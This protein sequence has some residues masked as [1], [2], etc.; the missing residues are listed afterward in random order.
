MEVL[1]VVQVPRELRNFH[2]ED[3][4]VRESHRQLLIEL[5]EHLSGEESENLSPPVI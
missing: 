1:E 2:P 3:Q 4:V 5:P